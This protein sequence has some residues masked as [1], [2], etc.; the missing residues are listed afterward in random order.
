M[1][2]HRADALWEAAG[3]QTTQAD[4]TEF[5]QLMT[6]GRGY[7]GIGVVFV[8]AAS[9]IAI[10]GPIVRPHA[11]DKEGRAGEQHK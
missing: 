1:K 10:A 3:L 5:F 4:E 11:G 8:V 7:L 9:I 2:L 6:M